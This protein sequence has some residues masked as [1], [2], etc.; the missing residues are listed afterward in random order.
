MTEQAPGQQHAPAG[1]RRVVRLVDIASAVGVHPS[2]VSRVLNGEG[3]HSL[4]HYFGFP[5]ACAGNQLQIP[6]RPSDG[7]FLR[8]SKLHDL[9]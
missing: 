4:R 1:R 6:W 2:T 8:V 9:S 5:G 3:G 7:L